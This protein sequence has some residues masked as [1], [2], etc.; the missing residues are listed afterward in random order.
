MIGVATIVVEQDCDDC[1]WHRD[2]C[3]FL[4]Q[5]WF[6]LQQLWLIATIVNITT[7][8]ITSVHFLVTIMHQSIHVRLNNKIEHLNILMWSSDFNQSS[9]INVYISDSRFNAFL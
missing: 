4:R 3:G 2:N 8:V 9:P 5:L 7:I 6:M 1:G